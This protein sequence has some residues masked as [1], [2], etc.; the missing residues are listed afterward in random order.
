MQ[1]ITIIEGVTLTATASTV[2]WFEGLRAA[3]QI[4]WEW[5]EEGWDDFL[6][7]LAEWR[8]GWF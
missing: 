7:S 4:D 8:A 1:T 5:D 2:R 3:S 6:E